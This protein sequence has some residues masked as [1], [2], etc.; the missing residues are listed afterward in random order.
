LAVKRPPCSFATVRFALVLLAG[1]A[2]SSGPKHEDAAPMTDPPPQPRTG[3]KVVL[4]GGKGEATVY[5]EVVKTDATVQRGLMYRQHLPPD[6]G[7]L[8]LMPGEHSEIHD[9]WPFWMHNTLIPL[10]IIWI[11]KAYTIVEIVTAKPMDDREVGGHH[12]APYVLE[13]NAGWAAAHG[14]AEGTKV[15]FDGVTR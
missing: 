15:R 2:C 1:A 3:P 4:A 5:V 14:V 9:G 6:D 12:P 13:V 7:M 8:F 10:D 11:D